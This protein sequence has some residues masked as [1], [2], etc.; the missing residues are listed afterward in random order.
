MVHFYCIQIAVGM[1][2]L[3]RF[4]FAIDPTCRILIET[5]ENSFTSPRFLEGV[6]RFPN[7]IYIE[8]L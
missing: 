1:I 6:P 5:I 4:Q 2:Q 3:A 8:N 7:I